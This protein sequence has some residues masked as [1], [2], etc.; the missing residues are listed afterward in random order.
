MELHGVFGLGYFRSATTARGADAG[1]R[2]MIS[3]TAFLPPV[4]DGLCP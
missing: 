4:A 3:A 2:Y 1:G